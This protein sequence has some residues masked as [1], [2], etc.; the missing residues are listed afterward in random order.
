MCRLFSSHGFLNDEDSGLFYKPLPDWVARGGFFWLIQT[1]TKTNEIVY[2]QV[3][4]VDISIT[5]YLPDPENMELCF[6]WSPLGTKSKFCVVCQ[7]RNISIFDQFSLT[8]HT[9]L[10]TYMFF[11]IRKIFIRKWASK[12]QNPFFCNCYFLFYKLCYNF[13]NSIYIELNIQKTPISIC[14][15]YFIMEFQMGE[16][17][18]GHQ[19]YK[20]Q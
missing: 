7:A 1:I 18:E 8:W 9:Y 20:I 16:L 11:Y 15:K 10:M 13:L 2:T 19:K 3:I 17:S 6:A 4:C 5:T 14:S 12:T